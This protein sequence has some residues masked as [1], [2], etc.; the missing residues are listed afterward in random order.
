[1]ESGNAERPA[2]RCIAWLG[3]GVASPLA[4]NVI[5]ADKERDCTSDDRTR[6]LPKRQAITLRVA[7]KNSHR[8][9]ESTA[10]HHS[11]TAA[12]AEN[13]ANLR[14]ASAQH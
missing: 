3:A 1:M 6:T 9:V 12:E 14:K 8:N 7:E 10:A 11:R 2:V 13:R 5:S 4:C